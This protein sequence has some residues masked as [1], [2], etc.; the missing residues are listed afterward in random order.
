MSLKKIVKNENLIIAGGAI[1]FVNMILPI[2][3]GLT[4][5]AISAINKTV[6]KWQ[7]DME[8]DK[9][10][11]EAASEVIAPAGSITHAIGFNIS[12]PEESEEYYEDE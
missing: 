1:I 4:N 11:A 2:L 6:N 7:L 5:M 3:D 10:E 8:L 9:A 12:S